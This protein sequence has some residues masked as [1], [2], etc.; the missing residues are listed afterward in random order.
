MNII[1][2]IGSGI[3]GNAVCEGMK[4]AFSCQVYDK[5]KPEAS[6]VESL[7]ELFTIVDGPLFVCVPSPM[8]ADGSASIHIVEEVIAELNKIVEDNVG[9]PA[10]HAP[11]IIKSTIPPG[12]T[13]YLNKSYPF[14]R[15]VFNPE[16][17]TEA[18][19]LEDF[20]NQKRIIIGGPHGAATLVKRL[21][22]AAY[23][24]VPTTKTSSTIAEMVKYVTNCFLATKV[25]FANEINQICEK[26]DIDYDK[27]IEYATQ[28]ERLGKSH[29]A[30]PGSDGKIG[31]GSKCFPKDINALI[32]CAKELGVDPKVMIAAWKKN[33]ELRPERDW[34]TIQGVICD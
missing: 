1:G 14:L 34:M 7:E 19:A 3:V 5:Y 12:T 10:E 21:Y 25:S 2:I 20:K 15:V 18:N 27:V 9:E 11:I 31:F 32:H 29:W 26:L 8:K 13:E 4:H 30:V 23:P 16:F 17:L 24:A 6:T 22:Q 33:I 28:D